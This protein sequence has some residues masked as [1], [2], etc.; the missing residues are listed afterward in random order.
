MKYIGAHVSASGGVQNAPQNAKEIGAKGFALFTKNQRRWK[1]KPLTEENIEEFKKNCQKYDYKPE[2]ILPHSG[3]LINL[4]QPE[5]AK[6]EKS[7]NAFYDEM[8]RC[9]QLDLQMLNFHPGNHLN[10]IS[11]EDCMKRIAESINLALDKTNGVTAV[12]ENTAG[13]GTALGYCFE[14]L[15]EIINMVDDQ[16]RVGVCYDTCHGF[17]AGYDIR[18]E[19]AFQKTFDQFSKIVGFDKLCGLHLNDAK[20][21]LGS[22]LD[23][24]ASIGK[25][26]IGKEGFELI[27][28]DERFDGIPIILETPKPEIW[29]EEIKMLYGM[30]NNN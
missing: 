13:Q 7:R 22:N 2:Q 26:L 1:S 21:D 25:G 16:T 8:Y 30:I 18:T 4:G 9:Q 12:L 10:Q 23:R 20:K 15:A 29:D 17:A 5:K 3:Y 6:L 24:H 11:S 28:L 14:E 27:M 19:K